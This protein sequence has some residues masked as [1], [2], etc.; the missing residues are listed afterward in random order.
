M[1]KRIFQIHQWCGL[2]AG[3]FI[4][5]MGITGSILVFHREIQFFQNREVSRVKNNLPV[6]I[7]KAY[8]IL[9]GEFPNAEILL[10]RF[11]HN[12][13][14]PYYLALELKESIY[15]SFRIHPRVTLLKLRTVQNRF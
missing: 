14:E 2:V 11:S 12:P 3:M 6:D 15:M 10:I 8:G 13:S 4:L 9:F 1:R 5:I 7:D